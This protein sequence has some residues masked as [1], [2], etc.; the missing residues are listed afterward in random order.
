LLTGAPSDKA[1]TPPPVLAGS[2]K[3]TEQSTVAFAGNETL[4]GLKSVTPIF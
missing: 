3:S 1:K 2:E 4:G